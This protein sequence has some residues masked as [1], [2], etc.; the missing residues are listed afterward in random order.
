M[1]EMKKYKLSELLTIKNGC[2]HK[3]LEDGDYPVFGSGGVM[4]YVDK[5]L[6]DKPSILLPRKGSISNIQYC[7]TPFWTVDT[8]YYTIVNEKLAHPYFLYRY[9][10]LLDMSTRITGTGLPS[11]TFDSY[12]NINVKLPPLP[13]QKRIASVLSALDK[14]IALNRQINEN[15]EALARQLYD[16]WFVQFDFPDANSKPYKSSGGKMVYNPILKREIPEG[17]EVKTINE[18][19]Q[20]TRGVT[21]NK[22]D[23][24]NQ[25]VDSI[26]VLRGNNI[27]SNSLV[28]DGNVAYVPHT[29]V[30]ASQRIK[31]FDIIMTMSSGSKAHIGKCVLFNYDSPDTFGAF[32]NKFS[33]PQEYVYLLFL[34]FISNEFKSKI[35]SICNGTGINNLTNESFNHI[36]LP[37]ANEEI[38]KHFKAV[39]APIFDSIGKNELEIVS[40]T[41]QRDELLPLLMNGQVTVE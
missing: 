35:Q 32:L 7:D 37:T 14:K 19:A 13:E 33:A 41:K 26:L 38:R 1:M 10:T 12:Y 23:L 6:Y 5:F 25:G 18:I 30:A 21:Y 8:L 11:M 16:Y 28:Y 17:W 4:R 34:H 36:L 9:L 20:S 31:K 22:S 27:E 3:H 24:V 2:D 40:L 29:L 15:L 39:C